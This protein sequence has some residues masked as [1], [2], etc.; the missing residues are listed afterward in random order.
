NPIREPAKDR[1]GRIGRVMGS[2]R[3]PR[4]PPAFGG[5]PF[6]CGEIWRVRVRVRWRIHDI[7]E[8]HR[9]DGVMAVEARVHTRRGSRTDV[10]S[11]SAWFAMIAC[12]TACEFARRKSPNPCLPQKILW[13][14]GLPDYP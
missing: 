10:S 7:S 4:S 6:Q 2:G 11:P 3:S 1:I 12:A 13:I 14:P 9:A 5:Q 8:K